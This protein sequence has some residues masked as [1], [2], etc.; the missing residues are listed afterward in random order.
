MELGSFDNSFGICK[1]FFILTFCFCSSGIDSG[2]M[3]L[4][5]LS[6]LADDIT[7]GDRGHC[8]SIGIYVWQ[9]TQLFRFVLLGRNSVEQNLKVVCT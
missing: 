5:L 6:A 4:P 8:L 7:L 9:L 3:L 1:P 2:T